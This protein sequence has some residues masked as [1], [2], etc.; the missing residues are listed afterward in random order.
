MACAIPTIVSNPAFG[1]ITD[2]NQ[3][4]L[5]I[6]APDDTEALNMAI[7]K[8]L[9]LSQQERQQIGDHLREG[10]ITEHSLATLIPKLISVMHTGEI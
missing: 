7:K 9:T 5:H 2:E 1:T 4:L 3:S 10:I 8:I 6:P